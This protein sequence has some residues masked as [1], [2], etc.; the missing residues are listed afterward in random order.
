MM[1][2]DHYASTNDYVTKI[3]FN[4]TMSFKISDKKLFKKYDKKWGKK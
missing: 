4:L 1:L 3:E 2:L